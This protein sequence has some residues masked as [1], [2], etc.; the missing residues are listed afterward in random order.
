MSKP[1]VISLFVLSVLA[2][3]VFQTVFPCNLPNSQDY[4]E[5]SRQVWESRFLNH[6]CHLVTN[7]AHYESIQPC[8]ELYPK[9]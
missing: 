1:I 9:E 8:Q 2:R 4:R 6:E 3:K 5:I 7:D